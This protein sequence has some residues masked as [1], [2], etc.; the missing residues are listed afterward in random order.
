MRLIDM[1]LLLY[2]IKKYEPETREAVVRII[3]EQTII[4]GISKDT[5]EALRNTGYKRSAEDV[6]GMMRF[7]SHRREKHTEEVY[8][9]REKDN[10]EN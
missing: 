2:R 10:E 9:G 7:D 1:D 3:K 4:E 8:N 6:L 5:L